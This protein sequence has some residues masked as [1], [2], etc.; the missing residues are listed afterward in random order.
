MVELGFITVEEEANMRIKQSVCCPVLKPEDMDLEDFFREV[1]RIGYAAVEIWYRGDDFEEFVELAHKNGLAVASM[2]GH[3]SLSD[4][5][6][7]RSNHE[8]IEEELRQSIDVAARHG[9]PG[10]ICFSGNG[11]PYQSEIEAIKAVADG[12]S[13]IARYARGW[14][15]RGLSFS[16]IST[17][18]R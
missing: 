11:Q 17:T 18:C 10:L 1:S 13:R 7:K 14:G 5:L 12:L 16:T 9:I 3:S 8:R 4:G 2:C 15:A 6:N